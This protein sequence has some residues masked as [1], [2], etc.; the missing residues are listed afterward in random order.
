M[1]KRYYGTAAY[2][3]LSGLTL[4]VASLG[5]GCINPATLAMPF[6]MFKDDKEPAK[7]PLTKDKKKEVTVVILASFANQ[8]DSRPEVQT[9]DRDLCVK[10]ADEMKKRFEANREKVKIV[11]YN[12]VKSFVNKDQDINLTDKREIGKHFKADFVINL[13]INSMSFYEGSYRQLFR[14][15]T[16]IM[17]SVFDVNG[18]EGDGP[19]HN[20]I[21]RTVYPESGPLDAGSESVLSFRNMFMNRLGRELSRWFA[22]YPVD[23]RIDM[24]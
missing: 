5:T 23:E 15:N 10:L 12:K 11:P 9:V 21:F 19:V 24:K 3:I 4:V 14:G 6:M 16:E 7:M 8:L 22:A 20:D 18:D 17:V 1:R 2:T 13:E